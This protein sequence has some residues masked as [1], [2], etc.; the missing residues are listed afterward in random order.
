MENQ[1]TSFEWKINEVQDQQK[2]KI[3]FI[4]KFFFIFIILILLYPPLGF[5]IIVM[6]IVAFMN[7]RQ[8]TSIK[9]EGSVILEKYKIN[10]SGI[11]VDNLKEGEK[12]FFPWNELVSFYSY[13]KINP[14][15]GFV[16][17]KIAGDDFVVVSKNNEQLKL[18]T[19]INET[20]KV[21]QM[22]LKKLGFKAP[23][24]S[25]NI[26]IPSLAKNPL[27]LFP[28]SSNLSFSDNRSNLHNPTNEKFTK[29]SQEKYFQEQRIAQKH[30][31][32]KEKDAFKRNFLI[33]AYLAMSFILLIAYLIFD[34]N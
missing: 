18:R 31:L 1:T 28:K 14:L 2:K 13:T 4:E 30:N 6:A 11:S 5:L 25:Q 34:K 3:N 9:Q 19:G 26:L 17:S 33:A 27:K 10:E 29:S 8:N 15:L 7:S 32:Q 22:L 16:V 23:N 12:S 21:Q 24:Q 20:L